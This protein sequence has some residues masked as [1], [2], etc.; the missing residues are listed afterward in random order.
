MENTP[1]K[2]ATFNYLFELVKEM[3][4]KLNL[5]KLRAFFDMNQLMVDVLHTDVTAL[6][7]RLF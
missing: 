7:H 5:V 2:T 6:K 4:D 1:T 3:L